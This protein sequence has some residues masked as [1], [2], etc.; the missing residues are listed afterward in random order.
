MCLVSVL[1][2][3]LEKLHTLKR[4]DRN[5]EFDLD[6]NMGNAFEMIYLR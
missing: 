6:R 5:I 1:Y 3:L 2:A 4:Y